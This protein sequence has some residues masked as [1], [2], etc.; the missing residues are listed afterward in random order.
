MNQIEQE[1]GG[2]ERKRF[3][4]SIAI[5]KLREDSRY[6]TTALP[7]GRTELRAEN[8]EK[9]YI[10]SVED[11]DGPAVGDV[12]KFLEKSFDPEYI[13]TEETTRGALRGRN[14]PERRADYL[15]QLVRNEQG[16]PEGILSSSYLPA[17]SEGGKDLGYGLVYINWIVVDEA[18]RNRGLA[19]ELYARTYE[20]A[21]KAAE[22]RGEYVRFV[23]GDACAT[24]EP[25]VNKMARARLYFQ[26]SEGQWEE[27]KYYHPALEWNKETGDPAEDAGTH[28][29]HA[30]IGL[31]SGERSV[32]TADVLAGARAAFEYNCVAE[33][34]AVTRGHE[35]MWE[36]KLDGTDPESN[37]LRQIKGVYEGMKQQLAG[38]DT[39][40]LISAEERKEMK[41]SGEEFIEHHVE[42]DDDPPQEEIGHE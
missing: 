21:Q 34:V 22:A 38:V 8:G 24:V 2:E 14:N 28:S 4:M 32:S 23:M 9:Y 25:V 20:Q 3:D 37:S 6:E 29:G 36:R 42:D 33:A 39:L 12:Q 31:M 13:D 41:A 5:Q 30:M 19:R 17:R 27:L 10:E 7:D 26:N 40:R 1:F 11:G 35:D 16:A 18:Q 15:I